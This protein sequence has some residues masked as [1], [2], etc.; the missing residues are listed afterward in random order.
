MGAGGKDASFERIMRASSIN[1]DEAGGLNERS[2]HFA[3]EHEAEAHVTSAIKGQQH[4]LLKK[5]HSKL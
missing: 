2:V 3:V 5:A 4:A 1:A